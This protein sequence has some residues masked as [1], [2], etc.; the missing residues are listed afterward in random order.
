M[1][2]L[3]RKADYA[4]IAAVYL[5]RQRASDAGPVSAREIGEA[6]DLPVPVLMNV[7]K[8]L[9]SAGLLRST[10]GSGGGYELAAEPTAVSL[11]DVVGAVAEGD[12]DAGEPTEAD[13]PVAGETVVGAL[14]KRLDGFFQR[15]TLAEL[16]RDSDSG[17]G[18]TIV[19]LRGLD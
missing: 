12:V 7:L 6:F 15:M 13:A 2:S 10:R 9:A 17:A 1:L 3:T 11:L 19:P 5:A 18:E 4:L 8:Q 16:L 14:R